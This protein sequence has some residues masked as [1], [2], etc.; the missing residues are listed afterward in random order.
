MDNQQEPNWN[1]NMGE[2][3]LHEVPATAASS[4]VA[5]DGDVSANGGGSHSAHFVAQQH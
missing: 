3:P 4:S 5:L 1:S 2:T